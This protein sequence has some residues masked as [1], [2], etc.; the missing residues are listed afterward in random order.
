[1]STRLYP[2]E[3]AARPFLPVLDLIVR[4]PNA[5]LTQ[6]VANAWATVFARE[7]SRLAVLDKSRSIDFVLDEFAKASARVLDDRRKLTTEQT[8]LDREYAQVAGSA[9]VES[10]L[11]RADSLD[12]LVA[13]A[14]AELFEIQVDVRAGQERLKKLE[15]E[16]ATLKP[17]IVLNKPIDD[18]R[19]AARGAS[20]TGQAVPT[21]ESNPVYLALAQQLSEDRVMV[22]SLAARERTLGEQLPQLRKQA[23]A[24]R[25]EYFEA[26]RRMLALERD[27]ELRLAPH[28]QAVEAAR[29]GF[30][31]LEQKIGDAQIAKAVSAPTVSVAAA[32]ALP[33]SPVA[34]AAWKYVA[35][36]AGLA[37]AG[38]LLALALLHYAGLLHAHGTRPPASAA[39]A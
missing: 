11:Q 16:L 39:S 14:E 5:E 36:A 34:V 7:Q 35:G 10:R 28:T 21:E 27:H 9:A 13:R 17:V 20:P 8:A 23:A 15:A 33:S 25:A 4:A 37:F 29:A 6:T 31:K 1:M 30:G 24:A 22:A 3:E 32:A 12:R 19:A 38:A 26:D 2:S 18:V